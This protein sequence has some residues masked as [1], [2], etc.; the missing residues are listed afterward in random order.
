MIGTLHM[1]IKGKVFFDNP[2]AQGYRGDGNLRALRMIR[3]SDGKAE[4]VAKCQ[5]ST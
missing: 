4:G 5:H 1:P 2:S 3:V